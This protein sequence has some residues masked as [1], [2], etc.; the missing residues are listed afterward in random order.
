[1]ADFMSWNTQPKHIPMYMLTSLKATLCCV[2]I[3]YKDQ[4]PRQGQSTPTVQQNPPNKW[5][6]L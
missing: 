6:T 1:M 2:E 3:S 5:L 4:R